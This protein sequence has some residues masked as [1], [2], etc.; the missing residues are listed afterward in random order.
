MR[1][2]LEF[3]KEGMS[4]YISHLDLQRA[5]SRAIR[6]SGLPVKM[7]EGFNPH[8]VVSFASALAVGV[9]SEAEC[10]EIAL[11]EYVK[12]ELFIFAI[13]NVMPPGLKVKRA[14]MLGKRAPKLMATAMESEY[15][16]TLNKVNLELLKSAVCDIMSKNSILAVKIAK[17]KEKQF[18]IRPMIYGL[19]ICGDTLTMRLCSAPSGS[20]K[21]EFVINEL[22][23]VSGEFDFSIKRTGLFAHKDGKAVDLLE[24]CADD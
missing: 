7:S 19:E 3:S 6:R 11:K 18:D 1:I 21:P 13:N 10:V 15:V 9:E 12:P 5:F 8:Y 23:K 24:F 16:L 20:L 4:K 22:K 14:M 2:G 17:G